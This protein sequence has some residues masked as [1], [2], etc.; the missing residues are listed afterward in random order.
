MSSSVEI[1]YESHLAPLYTWSAG[2][3]AA[4]RARFTALLDEHRLTPSRRGATAFDLGA[5]SGF[6][7]LP[8]AAAGYAVTAIDLSESLLVELACDATAAGLT[9]RTVRGDMCNFTQHATATPPELIVCAGDSLTHLSSLEHV[10][11]LIRDAASALAP[12]GHLLL[13]FRDYSTTRTGSD[14]FIPV[15]SDAD[16]ILTCFL[17]YGPNHLT[18]HDVLHSRDT[19][20]P[21]WKMS[22]SAYEKVR[23][24]P[25]FVRDQLL[26]SRLTM[27]HDDLTAGLVTFIA[28]KPLT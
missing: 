24:A 11:G 15:R 13:T 10:S 4:P 8:L 7:S 20:G 1:H 25:A 5:G 17:D 26:A 9:V 23:L 3:A 14:R 22:L 28:R 2:G 16:R 21:G 27:I 12:G 18:I 19:A 6:Q